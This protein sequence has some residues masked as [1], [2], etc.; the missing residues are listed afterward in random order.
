M[1]KLIDVDDLVKVIN[2]R[3]NWYGGFGDT[4][5]SVSELA[6]CIEKTPDKKREGDW[7]VKRSGCEGLG[8]I[9]ICP[10]CKNEVDCSPT[11]H[12]PNCGAKLK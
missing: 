8:D 9:Y 3:R 1:G 7:I 5:I 11:N 12:C 2:D 4:E 6:I 10:F